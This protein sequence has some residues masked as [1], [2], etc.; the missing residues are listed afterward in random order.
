MF[1]FWCDFEISKT[2]GYRYISD[3]YKVQ[4]TVRKQYT[5]SSAKGWKEMDN[6]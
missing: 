1:K 4:F 2:I 5:I 3:Y 6:G